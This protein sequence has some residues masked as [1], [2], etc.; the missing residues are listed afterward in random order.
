MTTSEPL[1][2][3]GAI[4]E[5]APIGLAEVDG[6]KLL[7]ANRRWR[8]W[9]LDD[10]MPPLAVESALAAAEPSGRMAFAELVA[11]QS[12]EPGPFVVE[13]A[14]T[15]ERQRHLRVR[16]EPL[17]D[18]PGH[19]ICTA[20]DVTDLVVDL[21]ELNRTTEAL[22]ASEQ[23]YRTLVTNAP[24]G[25]LLADR[26]GV[27][28]EANDA[29]CAIFGITREQARALEPLELAHPDDRAALNEA[30]DR[31]TAGDV[32]SF[33]LDHRLVLA[34]GTQRWVATTVATI[35]GD[36]AHD[37]DHYL[38]LL[39]DISRRMA[40]ELALEERED[41]FRTLAEQLPV[42]IYRT[43][44]DGNLLYTNPR[45]EEIVRIDDDNLGEA[46]Q[47]HRV[48][49][50]DREQVLAE[51]RAARR[52]RR[53]FQLT[54]RELDADGT[55]R[56]LSTRGTTITDEEG[57]PT[58]HLGSVEDITPLV[59]AHDETARLARIVES[60]SDLVGL[61]E[62]PGGQVVYLNRAARRRFGF[63]DDEPLGD[64]NIRDLYTESSSVRFTDEI[65]GVL[66]GGDVWNGELRML[67]RAG[68]AIEVW[69]TI[70]AGRDDTGA[71]TQLAAVGRDVTERRRMEA[72]LAHA[73]T[74]DPLTGLPNRVLLI[75]H[76]DL[77]LAHASRDA[78]VVAVLFLDLDRFKL[79]NDS[80]GHDAGDELLRE[81]ATRIS[82]VL[83]PGDTVARLGGDEFVVLCSD[84]RDEF[85]ALTIAQ[86]VAARLEAEPILLLGT[87]IEVSASI[88]VALS[89][90]A[91][92][93]PEGLLRGADAAMYRAKDHGRA[94]IELFDES[95]RRR[96]TERAHLADELAQAVERDQIRV[97][98]Q[99]GIDPRTG[100]VTC[101]EAL[102]RWE[103]PTRGLLLPKDFI[104]LA[105][106]TGL[107]VGLGLRVLTLACTQA[108]AWADELGD[109][110]PVV[111][112]NL[113]AAQLG[114]A[115][116][117]ELVDAVLEGTGLRPDLL[118]LEITE[119]VVMEDAEAAIGTLGRLRDLGVALAIDDF[120]TGYSSLSY[121]R[122]LPVSALKIDQSFVDGLGPDP[123]DSS[124][125]AA[126]VGLAATLEL[127]TIA[128]GVETTEQL[129][130]LAELG[131]TGAQGFLI[132][133][134]ADPASLAPSLTSGI[135]LGILGV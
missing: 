48:H 79:V 121:L 72:E 104:G 86:R 107:I 9:L 70:S 42:A 49:P 31:L 103:H 17:D 78:G 99:P 122:R 111:H 46:S 80:L 26:H 127:D 77:A 73:A 61:S 35:E 75:D 43:D 63:D 2:L 33:Q 12:A 4:G 15:G 100:A 62:H 89:S 131:C 85:H 23:R 5:H 13:V 101:V 105:E 55:T 8:E 94:R 98:Y 47:L 57:N 24:V 54:Y 92:T 74:H 6:T 28:R 58:G 40:A 44:L 134:P 34:D 81:V 113:S 93:H 83:R 82:E 41:L 110:A 11:R 76:L 38:V 14:T 132:A 25:Y 88:G 7:A 125:V 56:W 123:E 96:A 37:G 106:D 30:F 29:A 124:I 18:R 45:W 87:E 10:A 97:V 91:E 102:A 51:L 84:V 112:V 130:L 22:R 128:E 119:T 117:A 66:D 64:L 108:A 65:L 69:Q 129:K 21:E 3:G 53:A 36:D 95:M 115:N 16:A 109:R 118:C 27:V 19:L 39:R 32:T 1:E 71:I 68:E 20:T 50:D 135:E 120:G 133:R 59:E 116:L 67:G 60:T 114:A 126:I 52:E 90:D